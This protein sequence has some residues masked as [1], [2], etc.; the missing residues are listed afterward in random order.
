MRSGGSRGGLGKDLQEHT[1]KY[2]SENRL[3]Q[4]GLLHSTLPYIYEESTICNI[5]AGAV[6][7]YGPAKIHRSGQ[8]WRTNYAPDQRHLE[9]QGSQPPF[10]LAKYL[11]SASA[12]LVKTKTTLQ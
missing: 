8:Q 7:G 5:L 3:K 2:L 6:T 1:E 11:S 10:T 12:A 9:A 4:I